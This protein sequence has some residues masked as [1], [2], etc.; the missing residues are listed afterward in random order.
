MGTP[1]CILLNYSIWKFFVNQSGNPRKLIDRADSLNQYD[2]TG[3]SWADMNSVLG[4]AKELLDRG[5]YDQY[6][7]DNMCSQLQDAIDGLIA[8]SGPNPRGLAVGIEVDE[9]VRLAASND[10]SNNTDFAWSSSD[11]SVA[12]VSPAGVVTAH[13]AGLVT[14]A[15]SDGDS[16]QSI[17]VRVIDNSAPEPDPEPVTYND[18]HTDIVYSG[19][20]AYQNIAGMYDGDEHYSSSQN[21]SIE[22]A[23]E[24][25]GISYIG[26]KSSVRGYCDIYIDGRIVESNLG[27]Y[28]PTLSLQCELYRTGGLTPGQHTIK[29]VATGRKNPAA[30]GNVIGLDA[31]IVR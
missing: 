27:C 15:A 5:S 13:S 30:T 4:D 21:A 10:L 28:S 8:A 1:T 18:T 14:I 12:S 23:F 25:T 17:A 19:T 11:A 7:I 9:T 16:T 29:I 24:G 2:Y 26:T 22:F 6:S 3:A 20:F 31:F